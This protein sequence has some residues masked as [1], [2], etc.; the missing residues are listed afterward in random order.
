MDFPLE[1]HPIILKN[2]TDT[3]TYLNCRLV[4]RRWYH[5]LK[6][7]IIF[8]NKN[9]DEILVFNPDL[10]GFICTDYNTNKTTRKLIIKPLGGYTLELYGKN[11]YKNYNI[12]RKIISEPPYFLKKISLTPHSIEEK[13]YD[14]REDKPTIRQQY[15]PTSCAIS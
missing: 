11:H 4:C 5:L 6:D 3:Q 2:I 15:I 7:I 10:S 9:K 12:I 8:K 14:I 13:V 1:I